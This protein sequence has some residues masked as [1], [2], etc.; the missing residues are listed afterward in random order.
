MGDFLNL[1][2]DDIDVTKVQITN[3]M[4]AYAQLENYKVFHINDIHEDDGEKYYY[5]FEYRYYLTSYIVN[6]KKLPFTEMVL[7]LLRTN[8]NF[9]LIIKNDAESDEDILIESL[10]TIFKSMEIPTK[11][12][13][14]INCNERNNDLKVRLNT[15]I[16]TQTTNNGKCA[17]ANLLTKFPYEYKEDRSSL[18]MCYNRNV[19]SHRFAT[20]VRL[21]KQNIID[22]V[23]WSWIRG[24]EVRKNFLPINVDLK[25]CWFLLKIFTKDEIEYYQPEINEF[26]DIDIKKSVNELDYQVDFPP[27][28]FDW[29]A[30]YRNNPY[31]NSYINIV[32]ETN[33]DKDDI[34]I[35]SEKSFIPLYYSQIPII[36]SSTNHIKKMRDLYGFDFFDDIVNHDYD[37]E[38]DPKKRF[39]MIINEIVRLNGKKDEIVN[40]FKNNKERFDKN[41]EIFE[42]IKNDKTDYNFYNSLR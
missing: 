9:N 7:I 37:S 38:P 40:F 15:D 20:L 10:D 19:K 21:K 26:A 27:F 1:V 14:V 36:M 22:N 13:V 3:Y 35:L 16:K 12:I 5:F 17:I 30:S 28:N 11:K 41:I 24:Y 29:D 18:F 32:T 33:F 25:E 8:P 31:S 4:D 6:E 39:D 23:D 42:T 2:Y 34:I